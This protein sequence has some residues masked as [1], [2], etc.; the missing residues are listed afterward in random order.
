MINFFQSM[1]IFYSIPSWTQ[2]I[3]PNRQHSDLK[4]KSLKLSDGTR[5][6]KSM[7]NLIPYNYSNLESLIFN[8]ENMSDEFVA[9]LVRYCPS[10]LCFQ[11]SNCERLNTDSFLRMKLLTNIQV[12]TL[13]NADALTD[14]ILLQIFTSCKKIK[15]ISL[16]MTAV[17]FEAFASNHVFFSIQAIDL[18]LSDRIDDNS[19]HKIVASCPNLKALCLSNCRGI[20]EKS[21]EVIAENCQMLENLNISYCSIKKYS[22]VIKRFLK[23][24]GH[25]LNS[26]DFSGISD[27]RTSL[28]AQYCSHIEKLF[29]NHCPYLATEWVPYVLW[30]EVM[31]RNTLHNDKF[32]KEMISLGGKHEKYSLLQMCPLL[33]NL[34]IDLQKKK[35]DD[36]DFDLQAILQGGYNTKTLCLVELPQFDDNNLRDLKNFMDTEKIEHLNISGNAKVTAGG[37]WYAVENMK[38][39]K[40]MEVRGCDI[41]DSELD[42]LK[43]KI[44]MD[45]YDVDLIG[46]K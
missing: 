45:G 9:N 28:F 13:G 1:F 2:L 32:M 15:H 7:L 27:L 10:L 44:I 3:F 21:L 36:S 4:I 14:D 16:P 41:F 26:I 19:V 23:R 5:Y 34:Q 20:T 37:I 40:I 18:T 29:L 38:S 33:N 17:N 35:S 46:H 25:S 8:N 30:Q 42:A 6:S 11:S 31:Q 43:K 24:A 12:L 22:E 39:L